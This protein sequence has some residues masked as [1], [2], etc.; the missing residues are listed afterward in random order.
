MSPYIPPDVTTAVSSSIVSFLQ[1][2]WKYIIVA[3]GAGFLGYI[4]GSRS[5]TQA[6]V[7]PMYTMVTIMIPMM[8]IV[9]FMK[10]MMD[11]MKSFTE[12]A[13]GE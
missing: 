9:M 1:S 7:M 3:L 10:M 6:L 4:L 12:T 8:M 13:K 11:I 2:N 5:E